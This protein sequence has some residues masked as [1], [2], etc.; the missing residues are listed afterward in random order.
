MTDP[1][2]GLESIAQKLYEAGDAMISNGMAPTDNMVGI[3]CGL[4]AARVLLDGGSEQDAWTA[5][6]KVQAQASNLMLPKP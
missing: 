3:L 6:T 4:S 2:A 5:I 1:R